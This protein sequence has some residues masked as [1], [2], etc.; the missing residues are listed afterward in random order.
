MNE[1]VNDGSLSPAARE[2]DYSD[3]LREFAKGY[4]DSISSFKTDETRLIAMLQL[5]KAL[6]SYGAYIRSGQYKDI[7]DVQKDLAYLTEKA[8]AFF[9]SDFERALRAKNIC[10]KVWNLVIEILQEIQFNFFH[11]HI[12]QVQQFLQDSLK[13]GAI[14]DDK[15][16]DSF[17]IFSSHDLG[18]LDKM[19]TLSSMD[20]VKVADVPSHAVDMLVRVAASQLTLQEQLDEVCW[21]T[22]DDRPFLNLLYNSINTLKKV[23]VGPTFNSAERLAVT[24]N[25]RKLIDALAGRTEGNIVSSLKDETVVPGFNMNFTASGGPKADEHGKVVNVISVSPNYN[26]VEV[27]WSSRGSIQEYSF[28][29]NNEFEV[30]L[31]EGKESVMKINCALARSLNLHKAIVDILQQERVLS[32]VSAEYTTLFQS[33]YNLLAIFA[34]ADRHN[35]LLLA[36]PK[37]MDVFSSHIGKNYHSET[38]IR[39]IID[40]A[41]A[42]KTLSLTRIAQIVGMAIHVRLSG[43]DQFEQVPELFQLL[44][45]MLPDGSQIRLMNNEDR[46]DLHQVQKSILQ[47][48]IVHV[49]EASEFFKSPTILNCDDELHL[50]LL[51]LLTRC[52]SG[53]DGLKQTCEEMHESGFKL[54]KSARLMSL[55]TEISKNS[56]NI[57]DRY[58][59][60]LP[61]THFLSMYISENSSF[62]KI[63]TRK[64]NMHVN[65]VVKNVLKTV[66][67]EIAFL[68]TTLG[69]MTAAKDQRPDTVIAESPHPYEDNMETWTEVYLPF[70]YMQAVTKV[71]FFQETSTEKGYDTCSIVRVPLSW[72]QEKHTRIYKT[73]ESVKLKNGLLPSNYLVEVSCNLEYYHGDDPDPKQSLPGGYHKSEILNAWKA[74]KSDAN[75]EP[76]FKGELLE[77]KPAKVQICDDDGEEFDEKW[78]AKEYSGK[79]FPGLGEIDPLTVTENRFL[80][81]FHSDS[82]NPDWG[83]KLSAKVFDERPSTE[84]H[85]FQVA[86]EKPMKIL[87]ESKHD[88]GSYLNR[89]TTINMPESDYSGT[90][91]VFDDKTC[92]EENEDFLTF[93]KNYGRKE[94]WGDQK[95]SGENNSGNFPGTDNTPALYIPSKSFVLHFSTD[96]S[97]DMFGYRGIAYPADDPGFSANK[98]FA[99]STVES[100]HDVNEDVDFKVPLE[101]VLKD[102]TVFKNFGGLDAD[103]LHLRKVLCGTAQKKP[104]GDNDDGDDDVGKK[105]KDSDDGSTSRSSGS[106]SSS[107]S[108]DS[109]DTDDSSSCD[110]DDEDAMYNK[111]VAKDL[112]VHVQPKKQSPVLMTLTAGCDIEFDQYN[113]KWAKLDSKSKA[114]FGLE[115]DEDQGWVALPSVDM[116][117]RLGITSKVKVLESRNHSYERPSDEWFTVRIPEATSIAIYFDNRTSLHKTSYIQITDIDRKKCIGSPMR[118]EDFPFYPGRPIVVNASEICMHFNGDGSS[119]MWGF[120]A[121]CFDASLLSSLDDTVYE[122]NDTSTVLAHRRK[123]FKGKRFLEIDARYDAYKMVPMVLEE[124]ADYCPTKRVKQIIVY[125][126][127]IIKGVKFVYTDDSAEVFGSD[128]CEEQPPFCLCGDEIITEVRIRQSNFVDAIEFVTSHGRESPI[129]GTRTSYEDM[130]TYKA[131][132]GIVGIVTKQ[133]KPASCDN[134]HECKLGHMDDAQCLMCDERKSD[135]FWKCSQC[136]Y[137]CCKSCKMKI[138]YIDT[139]DLCTHT[140]LMDQPLSIKP[141]NTGSSSASGLTLATPQITNK[142]KQSAAAAALGTG[143][144]GASRSSQ[145]FKKAPQIHPEKPSEMDSRTGSDKSDSKVYVT[146]DDMIPNGIELTKSYNSGLQGE[147]KQSEDS[148]LESGVDDVANVTRETRKGRIWVPEGILRRKAPM[149]HAQKIKVT[150]ESVDQM[151]IYFHPRTELA[152]NDKIEVVKASGGKLVA[153]Y[154]VSNRNKW[155]SYKNPL[156]VKDSSAYIKYHKTSIFTWGYQMVSDYVPEDPFDKITAGKDP[157]KYVIVDNYEKEGH[158]VFKHDITL[159]DAKFIFI[160]FDKSTVLEGSDYIQF[161]RSESSTEYFGEEKYSGSYGKGNI[162]YYGAKTLPLAIRN[163]SV[164]VEFTSTGSISSKYRFIALDSSVFSDS[165]KLMR[166]VSQYPN[167]EIPME[168]DVRSGESKPLGAL[169]GSSTN[170][171][172]D[173][174]NRVRKDIYPDIYPAFRNRGSTPKVIMVDMPVKSSAYFEVYLVTDS[175]EKSYV[176]IGCMYEPCRISQLKGCI[177]LG[178]TFGSYGVDSHYSSRWADGQKLAPLPKQ[179][180]LSAGTVIGVSLDF[181]DDDSV[182]KVSYS[183]NGNIWGPDAFQIPLL[184][185]VGLCPAFTLMPGQA[186][187]INMGRVPFLCGH[188]KQKLAFRTISDKVDPKAKAW[189]DVWSCWQDITLSPSGLCD[190][191]ALDKLLKDNKIEDYNR[192]LETLRQVLK[193]QREKSRSLFGSKHPRTSMLVHKAGG[194]DLM[195]KFKGVGSH[196]SGAKELMLR[197]TIKEMKDSQ[198]H[199]ALRRQVGWLRVKNFLQSKIANLDTKQLPGSLDENNLQNL[200]VN[201]FKNQEAIEKAAVA[202]LKARLTKTFKGLLAVQTGFVFANKLGKNIFDVLIED[203]YTGKDML[204]IDTLHMGGPTLQVKK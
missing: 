111:G 198:T 113:G 170:Y 95:Y 101:L 199:N 18:Y 94:Y 45:D 41:S 67:E 203:D 194:R 20:S 87:F 187:C 23:K 174:I 66:D 138:L 31:Q 55:Y 88:Y 86:M 178:S 26:K 152:E 28:G 150:D 102:R 192:S 103:R 24:E 200:H 79:N 145:L 40:P 191:S 201:V 15:Y 140:G 156:R 135:D 126:D 75:L 127:D 109:D 128:K 182:V 130:L 158:S 108:D 189:D 42:F 59:V 184:D 151:N 37:T 19:V 132:E 69:E 165:I 197:K 164:L 16:N 71:V 161:R 131:T 195:H 181:A 1:R 121:V 53:N 49:R 143:G 168:D 134:G 176:Q 141:K 204:H 148:G 119:L 136:E 196:L 78:G 3:S 14:S 144:G 190:I 105:E 92:T 172:E 62:E 146:H 12:D 186:L 80:V 56:P 68:E 139:F 93:F 32:E 10:G 171:S 112:D 25:I 63:L 162:P 58:N 157:S 34:K 116:P 124:I 91:V 167:N 70:E 27:L 35:Q 175:T 84:A 177:G 118:G 183:Q 33:C 179:S 202:D 30:M 153:T 46:S 65:T 97:C 36:Q 6:V 123:V 72:S 82:S 129:Y 147:V 166:S 73:K 180:S 9:S 185:H 155:P 60:M 51:N 100:P 137:K 77:I 117:L 98:N 193:R 48:I 169:Q 85:P 107:D 115:C 76:K 89:F 29:V 149:K 160:F 104:D 133:K 64:T 52:L 154:D 83:W 47:T 159:K 120:R 173:S 57:I 122:I 110:S 39:A 54:F 8:T 96:Y 74:K 43:A 2:D 106:Y 114:D 4:L 142:R 38:A 21:Y 22:I 163:S 188:F 17:N 90:M 13:D 7:K 11:M 61:W 50:I 44:I 5:I 81:Y 125:E 99:Q